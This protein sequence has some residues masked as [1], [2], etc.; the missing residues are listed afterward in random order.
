MS[1]SANIDRRVPHIG[2]YRRALPVSLERLYENAIDWEHL[3]Y[4]HRSSFARVECAEAGGW[5]FRA[6]VW[7]QPYDERGAFVIE[8]KLD[9]ECQR[10]ITSTLEGPGR[11]TEVWTH[12]FPLAARE[13]HIVVDFFAPGVAPDRAHELFAF[14][15]ALYTRLYDEDVVMMCEREAQLDANRSRDI[16]ASSPRVLGPLEDVRRRLPMTIEER[17]RQFR[18]V[19]LDG[20]LVAHSA[21]CPH[22]LGPMGTTLVQNSTIECPWHGFRFDV[23]S[24]AC[25][26]GHNCKLAP[27]PTI[28]VD[29]RNVVCI[30]SEREAS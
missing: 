8:L 6:R 26:S 19:E 29:P 11:G 21:V 18:I 16:N 14:Y 22:S 13:T 28:F 25:V 20:Q 27:A 24:G 10:W 12:A 4:L 23:R 30:K 2:T 7:S 3:A 17:G 15:R 5:G 9:R 1:A